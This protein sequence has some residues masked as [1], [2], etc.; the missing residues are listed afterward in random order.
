MRVVPLRGRPTVGRHHEGLPAGRAAL[1]LCC[2]GTG[3]A[4]VRGVLQ[5]GAA[6]STC[7]GT[8]C[9]V[10]SGRHVPG[11]HYRAEW[12]RRLAIRLPCLLPACI[13]PAVLCCQHQ[14]GPHLIG[15][16]PSVWNGPEG[17][18]AARRAIA[19]AGVASHGLGLWLGHGEDGVVGEVEEEGVHGH[20][21]E[22]ARVKQHRFDEFEVEHVHDE[23]H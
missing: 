9:A 7:G 12:S 1:C 23:R 13:F 11:R 4:G 6:F 20:Q 3:K 10:H 5:R 17:P 21:H 16:T 2:R 22:I 19:G 14:K 15:A 18:C 8:V